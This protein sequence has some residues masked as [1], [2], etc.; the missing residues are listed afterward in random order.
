IPP[1]IR[2]SLAAA[3]EGGGSKLQQVEF[4]KKYEKSIVKMNEKQRHAAVY[5]E[6]Q[7]ADLSNH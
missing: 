5:Q 2:D 3:E 6:A 4:I 1:A 7:S